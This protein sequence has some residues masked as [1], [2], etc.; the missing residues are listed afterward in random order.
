MRV[1]KIFFLEN[2][3]TVL[4]VNRNEYDEYYSKNQKWELYLNGGRY[5]KL[6]D[7]KELSLLNQSKNLEEIPLETTTGLNKLKEINLEF[8]NIELKLFKN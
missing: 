7:L 3:L 2:G 1:K 4:V 8:N 5:E 6:N